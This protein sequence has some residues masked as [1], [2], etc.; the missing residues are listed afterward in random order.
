MNG[1]WG[2]SNGVKIYLPKRVCLINVTGRKTALYTVYEREEERK[3][4]QGLQTR[5]RENTS[6]AFENLGFLFWGM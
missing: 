2:T 4:I 6:E 3:R 1:C 5:E